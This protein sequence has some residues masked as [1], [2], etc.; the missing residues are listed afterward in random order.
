MASTTALGLEALKS[1]LWTASRVN[2]GLI[3]S[4]GSL[5]F[6]MVTNGT[7]TS[8]ATILRTASFALVEGMLSNVSL[9]LMTLQS[10]GFTTLMPSVGLEYLSPRET[11]LGAGGDGLTLATRFSFCKMVCGVASSWGEDFSI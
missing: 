9:F 7:V 4:Y 10:A 3:S 1:Y 5:Y 8:F 11:P 2:I 6:V